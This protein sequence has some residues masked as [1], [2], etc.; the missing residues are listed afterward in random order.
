M[1]VAARLGITR[2]CVETDATLVKVALMENSYRLSAVGG[3]ITEM[4]HLMNSEFVSCKISVCKRDCNKV[5]Q[6][7]AAF[8]CTFPNGQMNTWDDVPQAI[9]VLVI[10]DLAGSDDE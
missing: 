2:V 7:L 8:G 3:I 1:Q 9:E 6:N 10:S 4:K 5:A